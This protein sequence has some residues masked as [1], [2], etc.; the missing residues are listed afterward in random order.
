M[1]THRAD[2]GNHATLSTGSGTLHEECGIDMAMSAL[3]AVEESIVGNNHEHG[4]AFRQALPPSVLAA[5]AA[6][7][8]ALHKAASQPVMTAL[9]DGEYRWAKF[10]ACL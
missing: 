2:N 7:T 10:D 5:V 1:L 6:T 9:E 4:S 3:K 8:T